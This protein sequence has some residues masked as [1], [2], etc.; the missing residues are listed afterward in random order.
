MRKLLFGLVVLCGLQVSATTANTVE[1]TYTGGI[2]VLSPDSICGTGFDYCHNTLG[3]SDRISASA[4]FT[5]GVLQ[6]GCLGFPNAMGS[7]CTGTFP[8]VSLTANLD[9]FGNVSDWEI[10]FLSP[11]DR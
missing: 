1:Y 7:V 4:E 10:D 8:A 6:S 2:L 5:N 3:L 9:K 11:R